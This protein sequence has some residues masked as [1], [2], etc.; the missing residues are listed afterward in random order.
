[1]EFDSI[2]LGG[3]YLIKVYSLEISGSHKKGWWAHII[4]ERKLGGS[5]KGTMVPF[6]E[7]TVL[8]EQ[9]IQRVLR[10]GFNHIERSCGDIISV[11]QD[12]MNAV[13]PDP[14]LPKDIKIV[15]KYLVIVRERPPTGPRTLKKK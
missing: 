14:D 5:R 4:K 1:M 9:D 13:N 3:N 11:V 6:R 15:R 10:E 8:T 7:L 12:I 2:L